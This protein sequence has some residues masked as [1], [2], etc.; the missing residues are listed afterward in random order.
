MKK[1]ATTLLLIVLS[2]CSYGQ[3]LQVL[4]N[5]GPNLTSNSYSFNNLGTCG[6]PPY[7]YYNIP[8][9]GVSNPSSNSGQINLPN[10]AVIYTATV[11]DANGT[12]N[13]ETIL[14]SPFSNTPNNCKGGF[15]PNPTSSPYTFDFT[16]LSKPNTDILNWYWGD[17][18]S[19]VTAANVT[20]V[21]KTY[22]SQ[23]VYHPRVLSIDTN[24]FG[25]VCVDTS[26]YGQVTV[27]QCG[28]SNN[29]CN[30]AFT[31]TI[32]NGGVYFIN[33]S[34]T[35]NGGLTTNNYWTFGDGTTSNQT[36]PFHTYANP[37]AY[38]V[39]LV[40]KDSTSAGVCVDSIC[41]TIVV[42][43]FTPTCNANFTYSINPNGVHVF[44]NTSNNTSASYVWDFGDG[45]TSSQNNPSHYYPNNGI[46]NV[47]LKLY[48]AT[49][50]LCDSQCV[51]INV[52]NS[53]PCNLVA[54]A[55]PTYNTSSN[56]TVFASVN[57]GVSPYLFTYDFGDGTIMS[58][59]S[60]S[61]THQYTANGTYT[62]CVTVL[63]GNS[64]SFTSCGSV[65]IQTSQTCIAAFTA[66]Q[67]SLSGTVNFTNNSVLSTN[68]IY[69][70]WQFGDG[71]IG[72][73]SGNI[74][75]TYTASGTY[76]ACLYLIDS[77][78]A[79]ACDSIC[80]TIIV[81]TSAPLTCN[82]Q[83]TYTSNGCQGIFVNTSATGY[84]NA[85][86]V[87]GDGT[88]SVNMNQTVTHTYPATGVYYPQLIIYYGSPNTPNYCVDTSNIGQLYV[89]CSTTTT[90]NAAFTANQTTVSGLITFTN[91]SIYS[92]SSAI[93]Y[94]SFG[95][96]TTGF[97][98]G[99]TIHIYNS[100]GTYNVCLYIM[101]SINQTVCDSVCNTIA[102]LYVVQPTTCN[103]TMTYTSN[104]CQGIF[105]NTSAA[106]YNN[107]VWYFG[108]GTSVSNINSTVLH[109]Y[110]ATGV[111][112]PYL[113]V[114]YPG[115]NGA[116]CTDTSSLGQLYV[117]CGTPTNCNAIFTA[118]N[119]ANGTVTFANSSTYSVITGLSL[120]NFGDGTTAYSNGNINHTYTAN[121]T[122]QVCLYVLDSFTNIIC[123]SVCS[124]VVINNIN[125]ITCNA[126]MN[127]GSNVCQGIFINTSLSGYTN[128]LWVW[129]DGT[130]TINNNASV[131]HT[132]LSS[133]VYY[134]YLVITYANPSGGVCIDTSAIGQLPINC[135]TA[136]CNANF[137]F[138]NAPNGVINFSNTSSN[139]AFY[140][141]NFGDGTTSSSVN[142]T[143]TYTN[144][145]VFNVCLYLYNNNQTICDSQCTTIVVTNA[146]SNNCNANLT[147]YYDSTQCVGV[148]DINATGNVTNI[149]WYFGDGTSA[150][151]TSLSTLHAYPNNGVYTAFA[152]VVMVDSNGTT[153]VD[154]TLPQVIFAYC[155]SAPSCTASFTHA[156]N[157]AGGINFTNTSS[158]T[159]NTT[160][161]WYFGDGTSSTQI[162]PLHV[163]TLAGSYNVC[164]VMYN[165]TT[166]CVDST[167]TTI[168]VTIPQ[169]CNANYTFVSNGT[170]VAFTNT[171]TAVG[172]FSSAWYFG[173]GITSTQTNP[174][175]TY[176]VAGTYTVCLVIINNNCIDSVCQVINVVT[177]SSC[178]ANFTATVNGCNAVL[179]NTSTGNY[180]G[181]VWLLSDL[182]TAVLGG[183]ANQTVTKSY[184]GNGVYTECLA[185]Y[186]PGTSCLDTICKPV[187]IFNCNP[188]SISSIALIG[189]A[190][191]YPNPT[192]GNIT[193]SIDALKSELVN[194]LIMDALGKSVYEKKSNVV[195]GKNLITVPAENLA[196]SIYYIKLVDA[197]GNIKMLKFQK[198]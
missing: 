41:Q 104:G 150:S 169:T 29:N 50:V 89:N 99:N 168:N 145:G 45:T 12:S 184:P 70:Y 106:G 33:Q 175:Y 79:G 162:N 187:V 113:V 10:A 21:T 154:T 194:I 118:A 2:I 4:V 189:N 83:M 105:V 166:N 35:A 178:N 159:G 170:S 96:G 127:Y 128:A 192:A 63:D 133:G 82:A 186:A 54:T 80:D 171:S 135:S 195:S 115:L 125:P 110:P 97:S 141:W 116:I 174:S 164:L 151:T 13:S 179:T 32:V 176:P 101:D 87:W 165:I 196:S 81:N 23:G 153:C 131:T 120:W 19:T 138:S 76:T 137:V 156:Y 16:N 5:Y 90:C 17:G 8:A 197:N 193:L 9:S 88:S 146:S 140:I 65:T 27:Y 53:N 47:C 182:T 181:G 77:L 57:G 52:N 15:I 11:Q 129:G 85:L 155:G 78:A 190:S 42:P 31:D 46:Y 71:T 62:Y 130:T 91:N 102:V 98:N 139:A 30:A 172:T 39:C 38:N 7:T 1:I 75:H 123:D 148:L 183:A 18:T 132:Y 191:V 22:T 111:Y 173:N 95:D 167:C 94:W 185:I 60:S 72:Y 121:G 134:P 117:N 64:C 25:N 107:A 36:N 177:S 74:N 147:G 26:A 163:Y 149:T 142:P 56:I 143:H 3:N 158:A 103:A 109:T 108:D 43:G 69:S 49:N 44:T 55:T 73:S 126:T 122:Y 198:K 136:V 34:T 68:S 67:N 59:T 51:N 40:I 86:W 37:G 28:S 6:T 160:Y 20:T 152:I 66:S 188:N 114:S 48:S 14:F 124:N 180:I 58:N 93:S 84:T 161:I 119:L 144:N 157:P 61:S 100:I 112:Y 24:F 92:N